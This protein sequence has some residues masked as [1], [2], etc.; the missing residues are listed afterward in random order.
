MSYNG[1]PPTHRILFTDCPVTRA[2]R[3]AFFLFS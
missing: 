2:V 3:L 1:F